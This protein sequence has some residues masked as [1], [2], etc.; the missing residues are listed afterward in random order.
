M[1]L[2]KIYDIE[3]DRS[4]AYFENGEFLYHSEKILIKNEFNG[5]MSVTWL[6][7]LALYILDLVKEY[8]CDSPIVNGRI[9]IQDV[10]RL[11]QNRSM[12]SICDSV[13][14]YFEGLVICNNSIMLLFYIINLYYKQYHKNLVIFIL[15]A[16]SFQKRYRI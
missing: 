2:S 8:K 1:E 11:F 16:T 12:F 5:Y 10:N 6:C 3:N 9:M 13:N 7:N 14:I 15:W 4:I